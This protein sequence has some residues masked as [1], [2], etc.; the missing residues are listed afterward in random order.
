MGSKKPQ[1]EIINEQP[2]ETEGTEA[3]EQPEAVAPDALSEPTPEELLDLEKEKFL[4]LAAE[5]DNFRKRST[6]ERET[7]YHSAKADTVTKL[8]PVYDNMLR[9]LEAPC[10]DESFFKGIEMMMMQ[11]AEILQ[12]L[13]V[14][15][16]AAVGD[17]FDPERHNAVSQ[18]TE[19]GTESGVITAEF[20]KGFTLDKKVIR[21]SMVQVNT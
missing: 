12:G 18:A 20:Q 17:K 3:P 10:S 16:I 6:K 4:R 14:E 9:A 1:D 19:D 7:L 8:L 2:E 13:G 15:E 21:H 11:F 5:Y